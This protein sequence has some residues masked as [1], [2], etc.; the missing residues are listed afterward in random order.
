MLLLLQWGH[1]NTVYKNP[2]QL[3]FLHSDILPGKNYKKMA[4]PNYALDVLYYNGIPK[5]YI[6][7]TNILT[8]NLKNATPLTQKKC[9]K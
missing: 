2:R 8:V 7:V 9:E 3:I 4:S 6:N 5:I 1:N